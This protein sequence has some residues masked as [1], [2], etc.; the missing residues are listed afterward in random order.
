VVPNQKV[1]SAVVALAERL[2][3]NLQLIEIPGFDEAMRAMVD[4]CAALPKTV[5]IATG[6]R[7]SDESEI[8]FDMKLVVGAS[9]EEFDWS[10][11]QL[12]ILAYC[13][14][15]QI[16]I[17]SSITRPWLVDKLEQ[18]DL[19]RQS[20]RGFH[21][22]NAGYLMFAVN[23]TVRLPGAAC[24]IRTNGEE[25]RVVEG[26]LWSQKD[27]LGDLFDSVNQPFRLK[28]AVSEAVYPYPPLALKELLVNA[29]VHR[30]YDVDEPLR[31]DV[32]SHYIRLV[33]YGGLV[34]AVFQRVSTRLQEQIELGNRGIKGYRN[35][36]IADIFY[37]AGAMDKEG[38]GLP[39]VH[40]QVVQNEGKVF[41]GPVD[42]TNQTFRALIYRR[43]EEAD[44]TTRT[45]A[46]A[47]SKSNYYANLLQVLDTPDQVW[48]ARTDCVNGAEVIDRSGALVLPPFVLKRAAELVSFDDL[49]SPTSPF[50]G[51]I[52]SRTAEAIRTTTLTAT[53]DGRRNFVE[54]LNRGLHR[55]LQSRGLLVDAFKKR[56]YFGRTDLGPKEIKYQASFRHATR[57]VTKSVMSK[58]TD[59]VLYWQHEALGFGFESFGSEWAL[60]ILPGYV[61]TKDGR[62]VPLHYSKVGALATRKAARDFNMQVYNDLVFWTWVLAEGRDTF[63][64]ELGVG[65]AVSVRGLLLAC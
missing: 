33:N 40:A 52:D 41:F 12:Q 42:D 22:T 27:T 62:Y 61:F 5:E 55:Y 38:S 7:S 31:I 2:D 57:T 59:K 32:D 58:R 43:Q 36:V 11:V 28:G 64:I 49:S 39:D 23:P 53:S 16:E 45:A 10:R 4:T 34:E 3:G 56:T 51:S 54:L 6:W 30:A 46:P 17:P 48:R 25:E 37:G 29:L 50:R 18:L 1:H 26:N 60:R 15:M 47:T 13:R 21:P 19:L 63:G 14:K 20:E 44:T 24:R 65:C 8:P 35:P 9:I